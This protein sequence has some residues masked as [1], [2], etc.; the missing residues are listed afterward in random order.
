LV[1]RRY[2]ATHA[3][4]IES[5]FNIITPGGRG[6]KTLQEELRTLNRKDWKGILSI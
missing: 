3:E 4:K 1:L 6:L 2:F 5:W